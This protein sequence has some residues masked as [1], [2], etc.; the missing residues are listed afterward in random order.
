MNASFPLPVPSTVW[1]QMPPGRPTTQ[2]RLVP[3]EDRS[4]LA[5]SEPV[6][7]ETS[8][9][10]G[11]LLIINEQIKLAPMPLNPRRSNLQ[12]GKKPLPWNTS[13]ASERLLPSR[14]TERPVSD[15]LRKKLSPGLRAGM[16]MLLLAAGG[17]M[18]LYFLGFEQINHRRERIQWAR[19][20]Q[21]HEFENQ[22]LRRERHMMAGFLAMQ[23]LPGEPA[24]IMR[25]HYVVPETQSL[26][27]LSG[28]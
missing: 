26:N 11:A 23:G 17:L 12:F 5:P 3:R 4:C 10:L 18:T 20:L 16:A 19:Q 2:R 13:H 6:S 8:G 27:R 1:N 14:A 25:T 21:A 24:E 22:R 7:R 28:L 9:Q 15:F